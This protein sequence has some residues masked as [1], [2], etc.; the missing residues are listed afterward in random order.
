[1][2]DYAKHCE[3]IARCMGYPENTFLD[4]FN[5]NVKVQVQE[6]VSAN[7]V[8]ITLIRFMEETLRI[9]AIL[10]IG[11]KDNDS[12]YNDYCS[13]IW[14]GDASSL[15]HELV[16]VAAM[17]NIDVY[18]KAWPKSHN[19]L[20]Y[21]LGLASADLKEFGISVHRG[22]D[23]KTKLRYI[24]IRKTSSLPS[25]SSVAS[26]IE[27]NHAQHASEKG[28]DLN[29]RPPP[30]DDVTLGSS[31]KSPENRAQN[32]NG[33]DGYDGDGLFRNLQNST[34]NG[35][36]DRN[37]CLHTS[38]QQES[39]LSAH[40]ISKNFKCFYCDDLFS[41]DVERAKHR[42]VEHPECPLDWPTAED[43]VHRMER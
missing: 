13:L 31:P 40:T 20:S 35:T 36:N 22:T 17:N 3:M 1:M 16:N 11:P 9:R 14:R 15:L 29:T 37:D 2:V 24:E 28:D 21:K 41:S 43:F 23:T 38:Q 19:A 30:G 27:E 26:D 8:A 6:S 10:A 25:P 7:P 32:E 42:K 4:A 18:Q 12:R 34:P 33:D 5:R 39:E